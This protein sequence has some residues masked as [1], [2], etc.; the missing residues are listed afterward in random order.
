MRQFRKPEFRAYIHGAEWQHP[1][2]QCGHPQPRHDRRG[3]GRYPA[4][5]KDLSP[6][7]LRRVEQAC[8]QRTHTTRLRKC[9]KWQGFVCSILP[10]G[11]CEPAEFLFGNKFSI[12]AA[13]VQANDYRVQFAPV[14]ALK[15]VTGR[16]DPDFDQ[17]LGVLRVH[18]R[19]QRG[20]F[21]SRDMITDANGNTLP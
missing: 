18:A 7:H 16:S 13:Y 1:G 4:S 15:Q 17:Q 11:R 19:D 2:R 3:D 5:D 21:R 8:S 6:G 14:E 20:Q 9:G 12:A 10:A